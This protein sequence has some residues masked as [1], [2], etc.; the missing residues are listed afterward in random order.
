METIDHLETLSISKNPNMDMDKELDKI[1]TQKKIK[2]IGLGYNRFENFPDQIFELKTLEEIHFH[3]NDIT[4][5]DERLLK[6]PLLKKIKLSQNKTPI[7]ADLK[8]EFETKLPNCEI[9]Y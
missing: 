4:K 3:G 5:F 7:S 6:L 2:T 8:L 1:T 9:R